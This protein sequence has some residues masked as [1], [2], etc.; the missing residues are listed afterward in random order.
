MEWHN[1]QKNPNEAVILGGGINQRSILTLNITSGVYTPA[2]QLLTK[3]RYRPA[4]AM[5]SKG[6]FYIAG[7]YGSSKGM[8]VWYPDTGEVHLVSP[9]LPPEAQHSGDNSFV[10]S[11]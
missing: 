6:E 3:N 9:E 2:K 10:Y 11:L 1:F 7:G 4:C 5:G 8:D